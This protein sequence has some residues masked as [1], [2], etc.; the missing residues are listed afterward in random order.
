MVFEFQTSLCY[1]DQFLNQVYVYTVNKI[2]DITNTG[3]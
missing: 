3:K 1:T 2:F